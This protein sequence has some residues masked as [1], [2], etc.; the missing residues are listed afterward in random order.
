M[1]ICAAPAYLSHRGAPRN[2]AD[3]AAHDCLGFTNW[4][5]GGGW[6]LGRN[7]RGTTDLPSCRLISNNGQALRAAALRG[8]GI[9]MQPAALLADDVAAGRLVEV[10]AEFL[11]PPRPVNLVYL[12]DRRAPAKVV[13]F[14]EFMMRH[15][16]R[17]ARATHA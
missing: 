1:M 11:R 4:D 5:K 2:P 8:A 10:L 14:I 7:A 17:A 3:L 13:R 9:V 6:S 15:F 16:Q 12:R